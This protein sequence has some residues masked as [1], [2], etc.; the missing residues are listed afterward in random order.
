MATPKLT[1]GLALFL[2]L[3]LA[4]PLVHAAKSRPDQLVDAARDGNIEAV[5]SL[6]D[7]GLAVK[8][9]LA[10]NAVMT[11][12]RF[13]RMEIVEELL[14]RKLTPSSKHEEELFLISAFKG[15]ELILLSLLKDGVKLDSN[16]DARYYPS[17]RVGGRS[18]LEAARNGHALA[19]ELLLKE[20][21]STETINESG[22]YLS[23]EQ[24]HNQGRG[25]G[26]MRPISANPSEDCKGDTPLIAAAR[27]RSPQVVEL[28]LK[29]GAKVGARNDSGITAL[30]AAAVESEDL[31][32]LKLLLANGAD[33]AERD[34][35]G[36]NAAACAREHLE[37]VR[38][39]IAEASKRSSNSE[40]SQHWLREEEQREIRFTAVVEF[41]TQAAAEKGDPKKLG[42]PQPAA[43]PGPKFTL[44][45]N[46][47]CN[48][49]LDAYSDEACT[50]IAGRFDPP[51]RLE[52]M[53]LLD[54]SN[55][56]R[57]RVQ[58]P[59]GKDLTV[60]CKKGDAEEACTPDEPKTDPP[61]H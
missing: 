42:A 43:K 59:D 12:A 45:C 15:R 54:A 41:L 35:H 27:R 47:T 2:A 61:S 14:S 40:G 52:L 31:A 4:F 26:W 55:A 46:V 60:Y 1:H 44:P 57:A 30:M 38:K 50:K 24:R 19:V 32:T 49:H 20:K 56:Y 28:L 29:N 7:E 25:S 58:Q 23:P 18:L 13:G 9:D 33:S 48:R 11:A 51:A 10:D 5:R 34:R 22:H 6:L 53:E 39:R 37:E 3:T 21:V 16:L 8:G 17:G 36:R